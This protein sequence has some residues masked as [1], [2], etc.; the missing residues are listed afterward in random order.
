MN[1]FQQSFEL[2]IAAANKVISS[3]STSL[4]SERSK[5]QDICNGLKDD[6]D[7]FQS[8]ITSQ[9]SKL[10]EDLAMERKVM[11]ALAIK[12]EKVKTLFI[13]L[14]EPEKQ[15]HA[16]LSEKAVMR[17]Y[18]TDVSA[19]LLD[20]IEARN[21]MI[22]ITMRKHLAEKLWPTFVIIH[23]LEGFLESSGILKQGEIKQSQLL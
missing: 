9:L 7:K 1:K 10:Q 21:L 4:K 14:E 6:H 8:S 11:E 15:V 17:S 12:T 16:L 22:P 23:R 19:L 3:L 5:F 20:L 2:N 18:I 13:K